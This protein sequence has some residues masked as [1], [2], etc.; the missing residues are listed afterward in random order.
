M[1]V[2]KKVHHPNDVTN[3]YFSELIPKILHGYFRLPG[4]FVRNYTVRIVK[5]DGSEGEMD[6]LILVELENSRQ[7]KKIL[8][9]VEFQSSR[10]TEA[11]IK[12][13]SEYRDYAKAYYGLPVLSVIIITDGYESS[14]K[15]Y[16]VVSSDILRPVYIYMAWEKI[17]ERLKSLEEGFVNNLVF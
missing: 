13:I 3:V 12:A 10:V 15:E 8:I 17:T 14:E 9:N 5:K 7:F 1:I 4:K 16:S 6:W 11:K 2:T